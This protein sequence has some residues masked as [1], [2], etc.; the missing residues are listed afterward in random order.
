MRRERAGCDRG[1][2]DE[3]VLQAGLTINDSQSSL[4][5]FC[6]FSEPSGEV[7]ANLPLF[8]LCRS[9]SRLDSQ[10]IRLGDGFDG[11]EASARSHSLAADRLRQLVRPLDRGGTRR[12]R[13]HPPVDRRRKE[14]SERAVPKPAS[15]PADRRCRRHQVS[16]VH[17]PLYCPEL[18]PLP[19]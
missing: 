2:E 8:R 13:P 1:N 5:A 16:P 10:H 4:T 11:A 17:F 6:V 19:L 12:N 7:E 3:R 14:R 15:E 9:P 18:T